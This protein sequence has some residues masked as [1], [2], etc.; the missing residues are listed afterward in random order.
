MATP[1]VD[2]MIGENVTTWRP[3][4][5]PHEVVASDDPRHL[6]ELPVEAVLA[7]LERLLTALDSGRPALL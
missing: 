3:V 6:A 7:G 1:V 5:V 4:G 2:L